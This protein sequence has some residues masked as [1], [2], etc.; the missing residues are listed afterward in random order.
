MPTTRHHVTAETAIVAAFAL[1]SFG[2]PLR[3]QSL[4]SMLP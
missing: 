3:V 1:L 4:F 2:L